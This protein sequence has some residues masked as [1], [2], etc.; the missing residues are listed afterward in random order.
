MS[1]KAF[2][3]VQKQC[4]TFF[5]DI[6]LSLTGMKIVQNREFYFSYCLVLTTEHIQLKG[7]SL[8]NLVFQNKTLKRE[9]Q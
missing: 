1:Q 2:L 6:V 5:V 7:I 8:F 3:Y 4:K 9:N